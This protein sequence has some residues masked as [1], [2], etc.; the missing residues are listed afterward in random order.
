MLGAGGIPACG[1]HGALLGHGP[2]AP[3]Q[4]TGAGDDHVVGMVP[5]GPQASVALTPPPLGVP[6]EGLDAFG[7]LF[8]PPL[9]GSPAVGGVASGPGPFDPG[10][11]G[12]GMAGLRH[13]PLPAPRTRRRCRGDQAQGLHP[14]SRGREACQVAACRARGDSP[15]QRHATHG[16]ERLDP[17]GQAP[18]GDVLLARLF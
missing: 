17:R 9:A 12:R 13:G 2:Q 6:T 4:C 3:P 16:R 8:T 1:G 10:P 18:R 11:P 5:A 15:G 7:G 14:R